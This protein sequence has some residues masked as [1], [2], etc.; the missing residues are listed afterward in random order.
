MFGNA[1]PGAVLEQQREKR[2]RREKEPTMPPATEG[3]TEGR[4]DAYK[5][6]GFGALLV[7]ALKRRDQLRIGCPLS[8][9]RQAR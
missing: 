7:E 3:V 4:A 8:F 9:F 1:T 6:A 5:E 2:E